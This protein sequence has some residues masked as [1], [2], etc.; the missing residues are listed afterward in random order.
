VRDLLAA[1][2]E[3]LLYLLDEDEDEVPCNSDLRDAPFNTCLDFQAYIIRVSACVYSSEFKI[4]AF[5]FFI[6]LSF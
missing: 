2:T 1:T 6:Q 5:L 4:F 3:G